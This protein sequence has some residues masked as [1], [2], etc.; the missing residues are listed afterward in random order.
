MKDLDKTKEQLLEDILELRLKIEKLEAQQVFR[1]QAEENLKMAEERFTKAFHFSADPLVITSFSEGRYIAVNDAW[2]ETTGW[3]R[4]EA[5]GRTV[6]EIDIW[7]IEEQ[8]H[9]IRKL[10]VENNGVRSIE[11]DFRM[12]SGDI[13]SCLVSADVFGKP[14]DLHILWVFKDIT[15]QKQMEQALRLS[16]EKFSRAF[17]NNPDPISITTLSDV[18]YVEVNRAFTALTGYTREEVIGID[19]LHYDLWPD[20]KARER[21]VNLIRSQNHVTVDEEFVFRMKSGELRTFL[22]STDIIHLG[23]EPHLLF[24]TKDITDRKRME[25]ALRSSEEKFSRAFNASPVPMAITTRSEGRFIAVNDRFCSLLGYEK[26]TVIGKTSYKLGFWVDPEKRVQVELMLMHKEP[27]RDLE[28][29]FRTRPGELRLGSYSA[30]E[31]E[32]EGVSCILT[33]LNDIT[34]RKAAEEEIKYLSFHDKLTGLYNRAYFETELRRLDAERQ[35]PLSLILG[36]VNGLKLINDVLG[37]QEG[38]KLLVEVANIMRRTCRKEDIIARWGGDEFIMLLPRC[39]AVTASVVF[40]RLKNA[41]QHINKLPIETS[42]SVGL[43]IKNTPNQDIREIIK[44]AEDKMYRHKLL[45]D[46]SNRSSFLVSLEQTMWTRSHETREHCQRLQNMALQVGRAISLSSS[47]LDD[48]NL[49][50]ALHDI[51]KIAIP[52]SI[53]DK[54]GKLTNEEWETIKKHP[55][56]GYRI[57]LSSPEMAPIAEGILHHHERWDG[58]GYPLGLK[59]EEIPL[60]SRIITLVDACDVMMHGRPYQSANTR[61]EVRLE[62]ERCAGSQFEPGLVSIFVELFFQ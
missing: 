30:E 34:D 37:H 36:D 56:I 41:T 38:D 26:E 17:Q 57:A 53:L 35:L 42:L 3:Q 22:C 43:A 10:I 61:E 28:V 24:V 31:L 50:A 25:E 6:K 9:L 55:E 18:R 15:H 39:D 29:Y 16:E 8:K 51:G 14:D 5:V 58:T 60:V 12:K 27:V 46:K 45:E 33:I 19:A 20:P 32:V 44:E 40:E 4:D 47:E 62:I 48:L 7:V 1:E 49:L 52:N 23:N 11:M 54:P 2:I 21:F 13:R 59:G